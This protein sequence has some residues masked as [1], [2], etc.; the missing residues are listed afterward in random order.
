MNLSQPYYIEPRFG[1]NHLSLDGKWDFG[2]ESEQTEPDQVHYTMEANVPGT[3]F[4]QLYE[5][6][7]MPN[8]YVGM[9]NKEFGWTD[10]Q[11]WYY[12]R[13]FSV[14]GDQMQDKAILCLDGACYFTRVWL[15]G[16]LLGEHEG[17]FGG[18]YCEVSTLL[19]TEGENELIVEVRACNYRNPLFTPRN[20][21]K[22]VPF[23][24]IPWNLMRE[25]SC[26]DGYFNVIGLWRGVRIEFLPSTHLSRPYLYT[27]AIENDVADL[28]FEVEISDPQVEELRCMLSDSQPGWTEYT[29]GFRRGNTGTRQER[30]LDVLIELTERSTGNKVYSVRE[31]YFPTE[32][33]KTLSDPRYYECH[34]YQRKIHLEH[35]KLWNPCLIGE[36]ILYD[37]H[38]ALY[39]QGHLLDEQCFS[40]GI[41]T[42]ERDFSAGEKYRTRWDK[43][44]FIING[45]PI[46]LEGVNWMPI[47][48]F[49][50]LKPEEYRWSLQCAR[51][52]GVMM[53]RV[54]SGGG[55][56]ET[57]DFY[58]LCDEMGLMVWQDNFIANEDTPNWDYD[59]L[60]HQVSMNLYRIRNHPSL[61]I[62]C[63]GNEFNPYSRENL[64]AMSVIHDAIEDLDPSR[65]W[66]RTTPDR[67][68]AHI[69]EDMEPTWYRTITRQLPFL[70]ESGIHSFP[71]LKALRQVI[72]NDELTRP[73]SNIFTKEFE[74]GNPQLRNHFVEFV[75]ERIPRMLSRA[76]AI[77]D[78]DGIGLKDLAEATQMASFEFYQIMA[79]SL[80]ENY[81]ITTGLMPWVF[82]RPS[83]V[84]GVQLIDGLGNPIAP[85]YALRNAYQ[86]LSVSLVMEHNTF[87]P[88]ETFPLTACILNENSVAISMLELELEIYDPALQLYQH[89][90]LPVSLAADSTPQRFELGQFILPSEFTDRFFFLRLSLK[91]ETKVLCRKFYWPRCLSALEDKT[92]LLERREKPCPN[93]FIRKGPF[94]KKQVMDGSISHLTAELCAQG[95]E[96]DRQWAEILITNDGSCPAFP[97]VI[98]CERLPC[99][100]EDNF[101]ALIPGESRKIHVEMYM[102]N[103]ADP[104]RQLTITAWN[105]K[106]LTILL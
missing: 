11:V 59:I 73:L 100:A 24:I 26:L 77:N 10:D 101:F 36:P 68:S 49:L 44:H 33:D 25:D 105:A 55:I 96:G 27:E 18:P 64:A 1:A 9:N 35:P 84:V 5:A 15:N 7:K 23:P 47:D 94:L 34:H 53:I 50:I 92:L 21:H 99:L 19:K 32:W 86:P 89:Q 16:Q 31:A 29:F 74:E 62:H 4:W 43:F 52:M 57:D 69:Y 71:T 67:G 38:I 78:I 6:G 85:Y 91:N 76:S 102:R 3:V 40:S 80:R 87:A 93:L 12:R 48:H 45:N 72:T 17:M 104:E 60:L 66:V 2:Y 22:E 90:T 37:V 75:P 41:R 97:V 46:F 13:R 95:R 63:G 79:E 81:P 61:A 54:W 98:D 82:Q 20:S 14:S 30:Q 8:P 56:P 58:N 83:V 65:E 39:E 42:I 88:G 28:H 106:S 70:A 103:H 51:D